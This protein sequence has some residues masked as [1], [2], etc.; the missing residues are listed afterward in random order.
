MAEYTLS[1]SRDLHDKDRALDWLTALFPAALMALIH[2]RWSVV[3]LLL[4]AMAGYLAVA[5]LFK[6]TELLTCRVVPALVTGLLV[7]FGLPG[8]APLWAAALAGVVAALAAVLPTLLA[9]RWPHSEYAQPLLQPALVGC[10]LVW[11]VFPGLLSQA[12]IMPAQWATADGAMV[13]T[14]LPGLWDATVAIPTGRLFFGIYAGCMGQTC[15]PVLLLAAAYLLLRRR[16]RLIPF[17]CML[18]ATALASWVI[19][20]RP[21]YGVLAGGTLLAA[22]LLAD[23]TVAP[24]HYGAQIATGVTAAVV[25]VLLRAATHTDGMV[26]G[27]LLACLTGPLW[28]ILGRWIRR[29]VEWSVPRLKRILI[30][31]KKIEKNS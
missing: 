24:T 23:R 21:L 22:L 19:W 30:K 3:A 10:L 14:S 13:V 25:A 6:R 29:L 5:A 27:V 15:S 1:I 11:L 17:A 12:F 4:P 28:P 26:A 9:R 20:G 2:Y 16:L 8:G 18:A 31:I 7:V